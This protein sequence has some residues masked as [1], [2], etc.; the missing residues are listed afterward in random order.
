MEDKNEVTGLGPDGDQV[1]ESDSSE[2]QAAGGLAALIRQREVEVDEMRAAG[3]EPWPIG[4][5]PD[6]T[7]AQVVANFPD[8]EPSTDTGVT[9][10]VAGRI[11]VLRRM[12]GL[13]FAKIRDRS[14]DLQLFVPQQAL[15]EADFARFGDLHIGDYVGAEGEVISTRRGELS[16]KPSQFRLLAKALRPLPDKWHGVKDPEER[17]RRRYVDLAVNPQA[18]Q[19]ALART[20]VV[21]SIR[22]FLAERDFVEVETPVLQPIPG[23]AAAL[24]FI[25]HHNALDI[26]LYLRIALELHLKRLVVGGIE[27]VFEIG[28]VFRNEGIDTRH[29]PEFTMLESYSAF[30]D[31]FDMMELTESMVHAAA[32]SATGSAQ[33]PH[34][35]KVID[36]TP[37]WERITIVDALAQYG[38]IK[39]DLDMPTEVLRERAVAAGAKVADNW[40]P[41]K[42]IVETF[43]QLVERKVWGPVFICDYPAETSPLARAHRDDPR[44][45]ERFEAIVCGRELANAY[46]E[47]TDPLEQRKRLQE[48]AKLRAGGD[49]EAE[50]V[51]ED[52]L[53]ALEYGMPPCGGLGV[54]I[55]RLIML[56]ADTDTIRDVILF[57][58]YRPEQE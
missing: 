24:P 52:F 35:D 45:V 13:I 28:R 9:V 25:T 5:K 27:R 22:H 36:F 18:R 47:L 20:K 16:I 31:Y 15:S 44:Y 26:D 46:T 14:G 3:V 7:L 50:R 49:D 32:V 39:M 12:G 4:F 42:I 33:V 19:V 34:G 37:P 29:N 54:G 38:D 6:H 41:G 57:P 8:L 40:G 58:T 43:D 30:D 11:L 17:G 51:D 10:R 48:Q 2:A 23:G 21:A 53:R 56:L 1:E 55:D